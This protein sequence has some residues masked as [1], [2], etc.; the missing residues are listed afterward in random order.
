MLEIYERCGGPQV[1]LQLIPSNPLAWPLQQYRQDLE[2]LPGHA[3]SQSMLAQ[4][5]RLQTGLK[6][7]ES[8]HRLLSLLGHAEPRIALILSPSP[9][10]GYLE[11]YLQCFDR[12]TRLPTNPKPAIVGPSA[13]VIVS[14]RILRLYRMKGHMN[15]TISNG[16][17]LAAVAVT[18]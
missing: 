16:V 9:Q 7:A 2:R 10:R 15:T 3:D 18:M 1:F 14:R 13:G 4:F 11:A 6:S 12:V 5:A 17:F 8:H